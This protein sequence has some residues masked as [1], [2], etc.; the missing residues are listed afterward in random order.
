M[1][2]GPHHLVLHLTTAWRVQMIRHYGGVKITINSYQYNR[3]FI[4][5]YVTL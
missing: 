5:Q 4:K 2:Y 3:D 1:G